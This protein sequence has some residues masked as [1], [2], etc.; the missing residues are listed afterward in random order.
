MAKVK[1]VTMMNLVTPKAGA[2]NEICSTNQPY[3]ID[4]KNQPIL[5]FRRVCCQIWHWVDSLA[6]TSGQYSQ[7]FTFYVTYELT[8]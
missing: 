4:D 7:H 2:K 6:K 3:I 1:S 5:H 8:Q